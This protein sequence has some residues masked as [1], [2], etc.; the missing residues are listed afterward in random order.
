MLKKGKKIKTLLKDN[1]EFCMGYIDKEGYHYDSAQELLQSYLL[2]ICSCGRPID[3]YN[4]CI[5]VLS[6]IININSV[7]KD[8]SWEATI[9]LIND[10]NK[11]E[12]LE[13]GSSIGSSWLTDEGKKRVEGIF[14]PKDFL[15]CILFTFYF[16][17]QPIY[18]VNEAIKGDLE[19]ASKE[20]IKVF[21][22][23]E[24]ID[25]N[26]NLTSDGKYIVELG[27]RSYNEM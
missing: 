19:R 9:F 25:E 11:Q 16:S 3:N 10:L 17:D 4:F 27:Y 18:D 13:H 20:I 14:E 23:L 2:N 6:N 15:E 12:L 1:Y 5:D 24:L 22:K 8:K 21:R 7:I 26:F